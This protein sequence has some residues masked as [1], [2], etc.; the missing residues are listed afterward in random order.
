MPKSTAAPK[1]AR[2]LVCGTISRRVFKSVKSYNYFKCKKCQGV[3]VSPLHQRQFYLE[4]ET[5]LSDPK[6]Y[7]SRIDP[8]GQRWMIEQFE[9]LYFSKMQ[10]DQ[11]GNVLEVGAGVGYLTL[12]AL[13]RGW[14]AQGIEISGPSAAF[15][16]DY[17]RVDIQQS[18]I[19]DYQAQTTFD[20]IMMI[21]VLEHFHDPLEA[22]AAL[23]RLS[24]QPTFLFGTTPNTDSQ[25][26]RTSQQNIYEPEDHIFLFNKTSLQQ[27]ADKAGIKDLEIEFF[28]SGKDHDSNLMY[29]GVI[30]D[31]FPAATTA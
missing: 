3:F 27:F 22:L 11:R 15:G 31:Q 29:A 30:S 4:T 9:R 10:T 6:L 19:E 14:Q 28:G 17:F 16:R 21:E 5:Y 18:S 26:W 2:C 7:T 13:A 1:S 12:L 24:P 25:H 23:T 20:A 8:Y